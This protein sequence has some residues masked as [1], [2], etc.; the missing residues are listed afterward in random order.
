V[1]EWKGLLGIN[2]PVA[3]DSAGA[4]FQ[5]VVI[6]SISVNLWADTPLLPAGTRLYILFP[7]QVW[8]SFVRILS[9]RSCNTWWRRR[10][11]EEGI[12]FL[13]QQVN[14]EKMRTIRWCAMRQL[15]LLS[16]LVMTYLGLLVEEGPNIS[17]RLV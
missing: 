2:S 5:F 1:S 6:G 14:L 10:E 16:V 13:Q 17:G 15:F 8:A 9:G 12:R 4:G 3:R 11:C 7:N